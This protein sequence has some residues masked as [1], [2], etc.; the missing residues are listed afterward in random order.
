MPC[1]KKKNLIQKKFMQWVREG[2]SRRI[3]CN[4][5][6][7]QK[8]PFRTRGLAVLKFEMSR[9]NNNSSKV[10]FA[11][12]VCFPQKLIFSAF[13]SD[14]RFF[15]WHRSTFYCWM[16]TKLQYICFIFW[17]IIVYVFFCSVWCRYCQG[18][19]YSAGQNALKEPSLKKKE[20]L[21]KDLAMSL[22]PPGT[23]FKS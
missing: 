9:Q 13:W 15:W 20:L 3:I 8:N 21:W 19:Q 4:H 10:C 11:E 16:E 18:T 12:H 5:I 23:K 2:R 14:T 6:I 22:L 17:R 1:K 7:F